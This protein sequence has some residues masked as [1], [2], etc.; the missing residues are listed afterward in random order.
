MMIQTEFGC[1]GFF[2]GVFM[3]AD[4]KNEEAV[5]D[6]VDRRLVTIL[7]ANARTTTADLARQVGMSSPSV[8][9]RLRRLEESG[10]VRSYTVDLD[11]AALGYN[12]QAIVRIRP[13]PGQL[14]HVEQLLGDI[15]EFVECDKVTGDDCFIARILLRS[16]EHLDGILDRVTEHAETNTSIVKAS[17]IR[18]R[19]PPLR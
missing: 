2:C 10:I 15:P 16:I 9:D 11:P 6:G 14:R 5:L 3:G 19:L 17:T 12:L 18:R 8:A 7:A 13:L 1:F 4:L